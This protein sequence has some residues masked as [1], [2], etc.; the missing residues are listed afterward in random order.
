M[1][2]LNSQEEPEFV[3]SS[4]EKILQSVQFTGKAMRHQLPVSSFLPGALI[5]LEEG[6]SSGK[7]GS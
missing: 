1:L 5:S 3:I 7:Q 2:Q 6:L 4:K